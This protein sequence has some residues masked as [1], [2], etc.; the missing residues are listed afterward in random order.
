MYRYKHTLLKLP[1]SKSAGAHVP[2]YM[3]NE[4]EIQYIGRLRRKSFLE[5]N[6]RKN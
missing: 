1:E 6:E 3:L 2:K 5:Q 4:K